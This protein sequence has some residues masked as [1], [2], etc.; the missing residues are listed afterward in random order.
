MDSLQKYLS[1]PSFQLTDLGKK[2]VT[3]VCKGYSNAEIAKELGKTESVIKQCLTTIYGAMQVK[4]RAQLIVACLPHINY[5]EPTGE[6]ASKQPDGLYTINKQPMEHAMINTLAKAEQEFNA[7]Q[8]DMP[9]LGEVLADVQKD[10][11]QQAVDHDN[12]VLSQCDHSPSPT[13][14]YV[15]GM[16]SDVQ[17]LIEQR[18]FE[19]ATSVLN[20]IKLIIDQRMATKDE[21]GRHDYAPGEVARRTAATVGLD[22]DTASVEE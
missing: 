4:S 21:H 9:E 8:K 6:T 16:C 18:D 14:M 20:D 2:I 7:R 22:Q 5:K 15:M 19:R 13:S 10:F 1:E 17:E 12:A 11:D 3:L